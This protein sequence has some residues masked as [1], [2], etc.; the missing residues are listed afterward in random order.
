MHFNEVW[1]KLKNTLESS[2]TVAYAGCITC[3]SSGFC[4]RLS[5]DA[6]RSHI[7]PNHRASG[8]REARLQH[9]MY[10]KQLFATFVNNRS[11]SME[12][13]FE[14]ARNRFSR[15]LFDVFKLQN[16]QTCAGAGQRRGHRSPRRHF[17]KMRTSRWLRRCVLPPLS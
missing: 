10:G 14:G 13:A 2:T 9:C 4:T 6:S 7:V 8:Q 11:R 1:K 16:H 15:S 3:D 12:S 17:K 5:D